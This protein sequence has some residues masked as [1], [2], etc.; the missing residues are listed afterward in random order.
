MEYKKTPEQ[1][2]EPQMQATQTQEPQPKDP[3]TQAQK[4]QSFLE[5]EK[6]QIIPTIVRIEKAGNGRYIFDLGLEVL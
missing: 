6:M 5:A 4:L 2:Q 1:P 3:Q